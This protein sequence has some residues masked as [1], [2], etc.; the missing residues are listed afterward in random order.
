MP[1]RNLLSHFKKMVFVEFF[2]VLFFCMF[3]LNSIIYNR[4]NV[5]LH[6]FISLFMRKKLHP[7]TIGITLG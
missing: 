5:H 6:S 7:I 4:F 3:Y 2:H 1:K